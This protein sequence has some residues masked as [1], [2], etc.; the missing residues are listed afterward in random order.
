MLFLA[1]ALSYDEE[2]DESLKLINE[3]IAMREQSGAS[4]DEL[5][6]LYRLRSVNF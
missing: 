4:I 6:P 2:Y 1:E 3:V 5:L